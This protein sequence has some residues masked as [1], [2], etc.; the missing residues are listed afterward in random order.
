[1]C[2]FR[3]IGDNYSDKAKA[4][5]EANGEPECEIESKVA[6]LRAVAEAVGVDLDDVLPL[7]PSQSREMETPNE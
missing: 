5:D 7:Y 6:L 1:M 4:Y 2:V 3:M